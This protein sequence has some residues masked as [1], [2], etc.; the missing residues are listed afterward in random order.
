MTVF[1]SSITF[2]CL[3][4]IR[5]TGFGPT[6]R[7]LAASPASAVLVTA[8]YG[9]PSLPNQYVATACVVSAPNT[10]IR[11][12]TAAGV[13]SGHVWSVL[14]AGVWAATS[15]SVTTAYFP[16]II[17]AVNR[18]DPVNEWYAPS[19]LISTEGLADLVAIDG[20]NLA[21]ITT[22]DL[23]WQYWSASAPSILYT[24]RCRVG[25]GF[26]S[27]QMRC[28]TAPG[29]GASLSFQVSVRERLLL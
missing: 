23:T 10:I 3:P 7:R 4:Q 26:S 5:G 1:L 12:T 28:V 25:A 19:N 9:P 22:S 11:C 21:A 20:V 14:V 2:C 6:A 8:T 24:G 17:T 13:G 27:I 15:G 16:P 18:W 29:V